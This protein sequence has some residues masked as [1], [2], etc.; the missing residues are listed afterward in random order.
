VNVNGSFIPELDIIWRR[1]SPA[2]I[3]MQAACLH[4]EHTAFFKGYA[5]HRHSQPSCWWKDHI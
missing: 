5:S 3:C 1:Y 2:T 4:P